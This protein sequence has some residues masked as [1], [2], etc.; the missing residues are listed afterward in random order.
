MNQAT[1]IIEAP[2]PIVDPDPQASTPVGPAM[3]AT[4]P[5]EPECECQDVERCPVHFG[6]D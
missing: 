4:S 3:D 6:Y 1:A 2:A 5:V